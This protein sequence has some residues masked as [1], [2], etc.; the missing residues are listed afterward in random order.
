MTYFEMMRKLEIYGKIRVE[1]T[2]IREFLDFLNRN[3][4][5]ARTMAKDGYNEVILMS[6]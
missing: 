3:G 6:I 1:S 4:I 2:D 5:Y